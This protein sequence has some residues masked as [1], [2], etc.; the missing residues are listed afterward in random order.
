MSQSEE[1]EPK[2]KIGDE[3]TYIN[4][5]CVNWGLRTIT[6]MEQDKWGWKYFIS[7]T[8]TPWFPV[9][10]KNLYVPGTEP[11]FD[12]ELN[13][14]MTVKLVE[15]DWNGNR[16]YDI[17][18]RKAVLTDGF[19]YSTVGDWEEACCRLDEQFQPNIGKAEFPTE[20]NEM[21]CDKAIP[22]EDVAVEKTTGKN[23]FSSRS[24]D[25]P[26]NSSHAISPR[27]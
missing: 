16:Y 1:V 11:T 7:P 21:K 14:G 2:Y 10:E 13:N 8:D 26:E 19:L 4:D 9:K 20:S 24:T 5:Y 23:Y 17:G 15:T 3:V 6:G 25:K 22:T 27:R 12:L 18:G